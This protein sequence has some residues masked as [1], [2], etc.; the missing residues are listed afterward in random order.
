MRSGQRRDP[1][2]PGRRAGDRAGPWADI[3]ALARERAADYMVEVDWV[4]ADPGELP[5]ADASFDR[6][7]SV[8]GPGEELGT[9]EMRRVCRP[10]GAIAVATWTRRRR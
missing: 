10:G 7:V 2:G 5:F 9:R 3:L 8:F 6:V 1:G 4:E